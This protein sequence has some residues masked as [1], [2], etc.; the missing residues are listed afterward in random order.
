MWKIAGCKHWLC[1][2]KKAERDKQRENVEFRK[3]SLKDRTG[4]KKERTGI[5][6]KKKRKLDGG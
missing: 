3:K 4:G 6:G 1:Q 5:A 2:E